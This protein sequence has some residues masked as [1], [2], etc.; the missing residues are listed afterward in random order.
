MD[1]SFFLSLSLFS[2]VPIS[3][4]E[5]FHIHNS[6]PFLLFFYPCIFN[7]MSKSKMFFLS[8]FLPP[9]ICEQFFFLYFPHSP[10]SFCFSLFFLLSNPC[11]S[12]PSLCSLFLFNPARCSCVA[13]SSARVQRCLQEVHSQLA[14]CVCSV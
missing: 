3:N 14:V 9:L 8:P 13:V 12:V 4:R 5:H 10:S 2:S 6:F 1:L 7:F 11:F